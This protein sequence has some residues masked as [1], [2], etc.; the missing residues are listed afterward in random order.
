[1]VNGYN[2]KILR[3]HRANM[4][5][6][7]ILDPYACVA[8]IINYIN[9]SNRGLSKLLREVV[10]DA[11]RGNVSH[12][13]CLRRIGSKFLN[14]SEISVQEAVYMLLW[15]PMSERS[16]QVTFINTSPAP[17]RT[18][19][20]RSERELRALGEESTDIF[21]ENMTH[22]YSYRSAALEDCTLAAFY[23]NF[24]FVKARQPAPANRAAAADEDAEAAEDEVNVD[25]PD[26]NGDQDQN[27]QED[28]DGEEEQ[29]DAD[30]ERVEDFL[31][32]RRTERGRRVLLGR[33]K[34]RTC[35]RVIRYVRYSRQQDEP[36]YYREQLMLFLPWRNEET[37]LGE[38]INFVERYWQHHEQIENERLRFDPYN[39]ER[40]IEEAVDQA[41]QEI[42]R[43]EEEEARAAG[44]LPRPSPDEELENEYANLNRP[45]SQNQVDVFQQI[46]YEVPQ[47]RVERFVVRDIMNDDD[48]FKS[49]QDL[50]P[51][52]RM[53]ALEILR[54]SKSGH[55]FHIFVSGGAGVGKTYL[56]KTVTEMLDQFYTK[57]ENN[58]PETVKMAHTAPT[59]RAA[60]HIK[61]LTLHTAFHLPL[62]QFGGDLIPL[63]AEMRNRMRRNLRDLKVVII[64]EISMVSSRMMAQVDARMKDIF[65]TDAPFGG[66]A[67]IAVGDFNQLKPVGGRWIWAPP[68]N[69]LGLLATVEIS[70]STSH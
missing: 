16:R 53:I 23:A 18:R 43:E 1:M 32:Y 50:N 36:N 30:H 19:M 13:E 58:D 37:E 4:D 60:V 62:A 25:N 61:G 47:N 56:I 2:V 24:T 67:V 21:L 38:D 64:D 40:V 27:H 31:I 12:K 33:V 29:M 63:T 26:G 15:M 11:R 34:R 46:G 9:K 5:L 44:G 69:E 51:E 54:R 8:Y 57:W 52:Q 14:C 59:G 65:E 45:I 22:Y 68:N 41:E 3:L 6:Q 55:Q 70:S 42:V 7:F 48:F 17:Q 10:E 66:I 49:V 35:P 28:Q 20:V 39:Y